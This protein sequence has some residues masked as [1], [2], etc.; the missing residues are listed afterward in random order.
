MLGGRIFMSYRRT[1]SPA[2]TGRLKDRL[3]AHFRER[4][5][6][7][8]DSIAPGVEWDE[9]IA[10][11][12]SQSSACIV[13]IGPSWLNAKDEAGNRRLDDPGDIVRQEIAVVLKRQMRVFPVLVGGARMPAERELPTDLQALCRWNAI[14]IPEPYW[15]AAVEKLIKSLETAVAPSAQPRVSTPPARRTWVLPVSGILAVAIAVA[16]YLALRPNPGPS[17]NPGSN[18]GFQFAGNWRAVAIRSGQRTDEELNAYP[19]QS[20]RLVA[21][22]STAGIGKW[23][24]ASGADSLELSDAIN[25]TDND[26]F[27]CTWKDASAAREGLSGTCIDRMQNAWTVSLSRGAGRDV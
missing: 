22:N 2:H 16:L 9:E 12:L 18:A 13:I 11:H 8:V 15:D 4:V 3:A 7:D 25:L 20:F 23:K 17:P 27:S 21:Q 10:R 6:Q 26:K 1:D 19:D 24:Y 5:F 14:D